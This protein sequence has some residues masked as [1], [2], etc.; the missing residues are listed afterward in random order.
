[1]NSVWTSFIDFSVSMAM[2]IEASITRSNNYISACS[3]NQAR[4]A[5][6]L[7]KSLDINGLGAVQNSPLKPDTVTVLPAAWH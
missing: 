7:F 3:S 2:V 5:A 4:E 1:M 6:K